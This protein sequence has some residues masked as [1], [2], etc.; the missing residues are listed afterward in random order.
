M[1]GSFDDTDAQAD[2]QADAL[3]PAEFI[4]IAFAG[5]GFTGD[6]APALAE[7]VETGLVRIIDLAVVSKDA[8]GAV[9]VLEMQEL[10]PGIAAAFVKLD[11]RVRGL[12]S[13]SDLAEVAEDLPL[14]SSA[15]ALLV[16]HAWASRFASAVRAAGGELVL[17]ERIPHAVIVEARATLLAAA[18]E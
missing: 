5:N 16:E 10:S 15:A 3:G 1:T 17:A 9:T 14:G 12:L 4:V 2:A 18:A 8:V 6:I 13:E 11:G 7:L